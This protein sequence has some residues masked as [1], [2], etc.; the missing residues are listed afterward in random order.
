MPKNAAKLIL[1]ADDRTKS[2]FASVRSN[3]GSLTGLAAGL[4]VGLSAVGFAR[5]VK[6]AIDSTEALDKMAKRTGLSVEE[7]STLK[8]AAELSDSSL[9]TLANGVR[10]LNTAQLDAARG[11]KEQRD[12]FKALGIEYQN[13]DGTLRDTREVMD[14]IAD[15]FAGMEDGATKTALANKLLGRSGSELIPMFNNGADGI[16]R[17]QEGARALGEEISTDTAAAAAQFKDDLRDLEAGTNA[18]GLALAEDLVPW[19]NQTIAKF[20]A[21]SDAANGFWEALGVW[22]FTS[23]AEEDNPAGA[24][25]ELTVSLEKMKKLREE[26]SRPT[27]ANKVNDFIWGD[28][29]DLDVQ[30]AT[31]E[32]KISYLQALVKTQSENLAKRGRMADRPASGSGYR[33]SFGSTDDEADT[34]RKAIESIIN[35]LREQAATYGMASTQIDLYKLAQRGASAA[36]L[37]EAQA[38]V[39]DIDTLEAQT[40]ER[41]HAKQALEEHL[42]EQERLNAA[43][44][45]AAERVREMIDPLR[46]YK[47]ELDE[48]VVLLNAGKLSQEE[49]AKAASIV[50]DEMRKARDGVEEV[51][52]GAKDLGLTFSSALEDAIVKGGELSEVL[53]GLEQDI[54]RIVTRQLVTE[55]LA[56]N[57]TGLIGDLIPGFAR[58][59]S[60]L[61]GG[62]G[63]TDSQFVG[64]RA[65][66]GERVTVETPGQQRR[67]SGGITIIQH[68]EAPGGRVS[69][70]SANQAGVK[71]GLAV[72]RALNRNG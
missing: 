50:V 17:M 24:I 6:G 30:I 65:T 19:L 8:R 64:F 32:K 40:K 49:Y 38:I 41:E 2:A 1:S 51:A 52:R 55:P 3:L 36:Q 43:R 59:G 45:T 70:E 56:N 21:A 62:G 27:F 42:R 29:A 48:L 67:G 23:G 28:V 18:L 26:L 5:F 34:Q 68:I 9:E 31:T 20:K 39:I 11:S 15:R 53:K 58:G 46:T 66:P 72:Q 4:G 60:F 69:P 16:R 57:I 54:L 13:A 12:S 10:R 44:E 61:V 47:K 14:E 33:L 63:G 22:A 37:K 35:K 71:A 25:D 7:L